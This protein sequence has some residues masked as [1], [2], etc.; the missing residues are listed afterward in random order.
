MKPSL[1]GVTRANKT[2]AAKTI[3]TV[4]EI[5]DEAPAP[6]VLALSDA[7]VRPR[8]KLQRDLRHASR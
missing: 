8:L 1:A 2:A 6:R 5:G 3:A 7:S 4:Y